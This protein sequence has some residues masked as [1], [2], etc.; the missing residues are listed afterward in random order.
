MFFVVVNVV[1]Y[2]RRRRPFLRV[3][4]LLLKSAE[5]GRKIC[6]VN[7]PILLLLLYTLEFSLCSLVVEFLY[8]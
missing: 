3:L 6:H 1:Y 4:F 7:F 8:S 5:L 2:V